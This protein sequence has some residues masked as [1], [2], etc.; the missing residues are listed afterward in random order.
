MFNSGFST[1]NDYDN[2]AGNHTVDNGGA[3]KNYTAAGNDRPDYS[4]GNLDLAHAGT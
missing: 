4:A 1:G 2:T 3:N